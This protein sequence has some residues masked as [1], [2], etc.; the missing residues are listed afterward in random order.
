MSKMIDFTSVTSVLDSNF[1][2]HE[3]VESWLNL[4]IRL[5][6]EL[7]TASALL[8]HRGY[9]GCLSFSHWHEEETVIRLLPNTP[10]ALCP[11][12]AVFSNSVEG[13]TI[14]SRIGQFIPAQMVRRER[15]IG[16]ARLKKKLEAKFFEF[17]SSFNEDVSAIK[18]V[19]TA[20]D[21]LDQEPN[22]RKINTG[23][24]W[25][26]I[27]LN[28]E[29]YQ[30]FAGLS[31]KKRHGLGQWVST[32]ITGSP[33]PVD[34]ILRRYVVYHILYKTGVDV[35]AAVWELTLRDI[36]FDVSFSVVLSG[37]FGNGAWDRGALG[38]GVCWLME[39]EPKDIPI[40]P[41][42]WEGVKQFAA[43]PKIYDGSLHL[44]FAREI[45]SENPELAYTHACNAACQW[46][47]ATQK[48]PI[49]A[50]V[51]AHELAVAND[52]G[53]LATILGWSRDIFGR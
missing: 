33:S 45:A 51:F 25:V 27:D 36:V 29:L 7:T 6:E 13:E 1:P 4:N 19:L 35:T 40:S 22:K 41:I 18:N 12:A 14:A 43:S 53:D 30:M 2:H 3:D 42:L 34:M 20:A 37:W 39:Q 10:L 15:G 8:A 49:D 26:A 44:E 11:V 21:I 38:Q 50:T 17:A 9:L 31:Q 48:I 28:D 16:R 32:I 52:W 47:R 24:M 46:V 5:E 23:P